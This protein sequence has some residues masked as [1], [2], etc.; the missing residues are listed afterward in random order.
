MGRHCRPFPPRSGALEE[1]PVEFR[2]ELGGR[3]IDL[4]AIRHLL[5]EAD[6]A[7]LADL[8][9][10]NAVLRV[11]AQL[12]GGEVLGLLAEAGCEMP[13]QALQAQPSVCC[14]GCGG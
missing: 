1:T 13:P 9:P 10:F 4:A 6:P 7:A 3:A 2:I 11:A 8:D 5:R 12:T 14:G